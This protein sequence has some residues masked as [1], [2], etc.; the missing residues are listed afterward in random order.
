MMKSKYLALLMAVTPMHV[1]AQT[2][3]GL[4]FSQL[5]L[6]F[7]ILIGL[8]CSVYVFALANRIKGGKLGSALAFYG[9]GMLSVVVSLLSVT[10]LKTRV[11]DSAPMIHDLFF[12]IGFALMVVAT[13]KVARINRFMQQR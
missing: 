10:W 8:C 13:T 5:L 3:N 6:T 7:A 11:G 12:I 2:N 1:S 9:L 4:P